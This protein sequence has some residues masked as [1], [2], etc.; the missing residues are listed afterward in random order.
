MMMGVLQVV[1]RGRVT[2]C[3]GLMVMLDGRA[4]GLFCHN[5]G[6]LQRSLER[7]SPGAQG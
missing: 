5:S 6:L 3:G 2:V 1:V 4:F 7:W